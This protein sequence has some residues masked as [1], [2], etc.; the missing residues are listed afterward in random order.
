MAKH[1][2]LKGRRKTDIVTNHK[3]GS[4][5]P[6][7]VGDEPMKEFI[8]APYAIMGHP[9][10]DLDQTAPLEERRA[11]GGDKVLLTKSQAEWC[12]ANG[13]IDSTLPDFEPAPIPAP[14]GGRPKDGAAEKV[15]RPAADRKADASL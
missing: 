7:R 1:P 10:L 12:L 2:E 13:F 4:T 14:D 3:K 8:V 15:T 9:N 5:M 11:V 6:P